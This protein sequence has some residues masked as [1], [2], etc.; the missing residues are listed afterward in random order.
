MSDSV[1]AMI[2]LSDSARQELEKFRRAH[3]TKVLTIF[4]SD[5]VGSTKL[6]VEHGNVVAAGMVRQH[7]AMMRRIL[8]SFDGKEISTSGDSMLIVF[9]APADAVKF[10]L[11]VEKAMREAHL[12][13][14]LMPSMRSGIHHG[15]VVLQMEPGQED[16][17]DIFGVQVSTAARI[18]S[19]GEGRQILVSRAVYDDA[20]MVLAHE[21]LQ[22]LGELYWANH[23]AYR[24]KGIPEEYDV[25]EVG[26]HAFAPMRPPQSGDKAWRVESP[27][28][29][30][31]H[32]FAESKSARP[33]F[34]LRW[35]IAAVVLLVA[36][37]ITAFVVNKQPVMPAKRPMPVEEV[38]TDPRLRL[39]QIEA[40]LA[41][42]SGVEEEL[43]SMSELD[44]LY[45]KATDAIFS[46]APAQ[47]RSETLK[48]LERLRNYE[49]TVEEQSFVD[50]ADELAN[51][52][53][54]I[55]PEEI[56]TPVRRLAEQLVSRR[57]SL[58]REKQQLE[59]NL[60]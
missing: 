18:M 40:K 16:F 23:G 53:I 46:G 48:F 6:Q 26:E 15:Q 24:F 28:K 59:V 17:S 55:Y 39:A 45:R 4:F 58:L 51:A 60:K 14:P 20:R 3:E 1:G 36:T 49:L 8:E 47:V 38:A 32:A 54:S 34:S 52:T 7:Y 11:S 10:A 33:N 19:L 12:R 13:D 30:P 56:Y 44:A 37:T 22:G 50:K 41:R 5:L 31:A 35:V 43:D 2:P 21:S 27:P 42:L 57:K 29:P 9:A 25:C